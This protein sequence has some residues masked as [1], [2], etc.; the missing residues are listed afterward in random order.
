MFV[1]AVYKTVEVNLAP[2]KMKM[3]ILYFLQHPRLDTLAYGR[4]PGMSI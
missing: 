4:L 2:R 1:V 3:K